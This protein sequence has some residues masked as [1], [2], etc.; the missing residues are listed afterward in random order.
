MR[1]FTGAALAAMVVLSGPGLTW[2]AP[3]AEPAT[4]TIKMVYDA[5]GAAKARTPALVLGENRFSVGSD[6][7]MGIKV[8]GTTVKTSAR[9]KGRDILIGFDSNG[10]GKI[11]KSEW[12]AIPMTRT[13]KLSGKVDGKQFVINLVNIWADYN[14]TTVN[15]WGQTLIRSS[16]KGSVGGIPVR[17]LDDDLDGKF[18]QKPSGRGG[19]A[20]L[21]GNSSAAIPLR[22]VHK[23]GKDFYR[24]KVSQDGSSIDY[25]RLDDTAVGRVEATFPTDT[26]KAL[27]LVSEDSAFDMRTDGASG[28]PAGKYKLS[29]GVVSTASALLTFRPSGTT[30]DYDI[31]AGMINTLR[32]GK[33]VRLAFGANYRAGKIG[34]SA[35]AVWVVGSGTEIYGRLN[36]N[37]GGNVRPPRVSI[38][39][40]DK[41]I[42]TA[43]MEYG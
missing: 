12:T 26:L 42:S 17:I 8:A 5:G 4:G 31:Q 20:I 1:Y 41:T 21:I 6:S 23:I 19:D 24:L 16:M 43:N 18:N 29:Y 33:P 22:Q 10:D 14:R 32:I 37:K 25:Q 2:G 35:G 27:V 40:G 36:F 3:A 34:L 11:S 9:V 28:I 39:D 15:C 7:T 38:L 13:L 30:P